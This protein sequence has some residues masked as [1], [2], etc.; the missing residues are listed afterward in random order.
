[1]LGMLVKVNGV[2]SMKNLIYNLRL[3]LFGL[4]FG[5]II[6]IIPKKCIKTWQWIAIMPFED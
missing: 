6:K 1:M 4:L 5:L 2:N 3:A